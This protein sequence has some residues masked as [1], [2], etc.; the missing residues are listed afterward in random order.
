MI[1]GLAALSAALVMLAGAAVAQ[2]RASVPLDGEW[3][4]FKGDT[5]EASASRFDDSAWEIV[6]TPHTWNGADGEDGGLYY[7]G[8]GWYR[9][10][11]VR[12][13]GAQRLWLEFDGAALAADAWVNGVHVGRHE[14]GYARFR[15][16]ITDAVRAGRN[17]LAVRVDNSALS[18]IAPLGGDFTV[19]GGL[20]RPVRLVTANAVHFDL[21]D[22]GGPGVYMSAASVSAA[23]ADLSILL[24]LANDGDRARRL[25]VRTTLRD[26]SGAE[27]FEAMTEAEI[28]ARG[29]ISLTHAGELANPRLWNGR[30]DPHLYR[31]TA[32]IVDSRGRVLDRVSFD[33]GVRAAAFD[34][35]RGFSL[36]GRSYPLF[37]VNYQVGGRPGR[38][39]AI[40]DAEIDEDMRIIEELGATAVRFAHMQHA[41]RAY[42]LADELGLA[43]WTEA[44]LV[45]AANASPEFAANITQQMRELIRQN[46][47]HPS[48]M[49]W[50]IGNELYA[51]DEVVD[52]SLALVQSVAREEDPSRPTVYAHCCQDDLHPIA[53]R[54]DL[55]AYNRYYGWYDQ[56]MARIGAWA[57]ELHAR[58]PE[59][60]I[61]VSEYGAG[62]SVL[63][64]RDPPD[65]PAPAGRWHPEQYQTR[66]H[67]TYW[68]ALRERPFLWGNFVWVAFDFASD[69][70]NE[71]DH[72]GIN[73]K[74]LVTYDRAVRKD[75]WYWYQA[76]WSARPMAHIL[77]RRL[78]TEADGPIDLRVYS[79]LERLALVV[80]GIERGV[81]TVNDYVAEWRSVAL[82]PGLNRIEARG[83]G[84]VDVIFVQAR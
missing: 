79:N 35:A 68:R 44:P 65:R 15:F 52:A 33:T 45:A 72:A 16:D 32:E 7:R 77:N 46:Q 62:A 38:G 22:Y 48:V 41:Q 31:L 83:E 5:P 63:H 60:A 20:H 42:D 58:A 54:A 66:F 34:A 78:L 49:L 26:A 13:A 2:P 80:N 70:R 56:E 36:N 9:T 28:P 67:E 82:E 81:A 61:A 76:N 40:G 14:G 47:H 12:P 23:R 73:D 27:V 17:V 3:R 8:A 19:F 59:R 53:R 11:F 75:A 25:R 39:T 51:A 4:F 69:G 29:R 84:V 57:D 18:H 50:G 1:K 24:R 64:Q 55:G 10:A 6:R 43:V 71:G 30:S 37:G 74:G 21:A